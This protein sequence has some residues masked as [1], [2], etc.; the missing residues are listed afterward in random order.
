MESG[1]QIVLSHVTRPAKCEGSELI[2]ALFLINVD[3][4]IYSI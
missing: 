1:P 3:C 4:C 2:E